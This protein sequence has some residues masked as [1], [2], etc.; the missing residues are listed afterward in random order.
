MLDVDGPMEETVGGNQ[1]KEVGT[2]EEYDLIVKLD[3]QR[4]NRTEGL[5][6]KLP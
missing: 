1:E 6:V 5:I 4:N 2:S 3:I